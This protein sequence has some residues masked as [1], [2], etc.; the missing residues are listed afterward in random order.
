MI[1]LSNHKF[2]CD[3]KNA[4]LVLPLWPIKRRNTKFICAVYQC[5]ICGE[6]S[7]RG[8]SENKSWNTLTQILTEEM[9]IKLKNR[10]EIR[11]GLEIQNTR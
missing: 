9:Y 7:I 1:K 4:R 11:Y 10:K 3:G 2:C 5:L 8:E 6:Y